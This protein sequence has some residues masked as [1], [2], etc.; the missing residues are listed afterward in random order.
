[1]I[2][3]PSEKAPAPASPSIMAQDLQLIHLVTF[4]VIMGH[5][6]L[7]RSAPFSISITEADGLFC[8]IRHAHISP[9]MPPPIIAISYLFFIYLYHAFHSTFIIQSNYS[10]LYKFCPQSLNSNF[11]F[12]ADKFISHNILFTIIKA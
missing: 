12:F 11:N 1:M 5:T 9:P 10:R 3:L 6:L 2:Y 8:F 4:F 7:S